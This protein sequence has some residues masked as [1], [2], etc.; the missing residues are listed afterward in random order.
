MTPVFNLHVKKSSNIFL[1]I[2]TS[3]F[4]KASNR[5]PDLT[6]FVHG[7]FGS[8]LKMLKWKMLS[9]IFLII[10]ILDYDDMLSK[11]CNRIF[12]VNLMFYRKKGF[13]V[14][15]YAKVKLILGLVIAKNLLRKWSQKA[16]IFLINRKIIILK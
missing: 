7:G 16:G 8:T 12:F 11:L 4:M 3:S 15:N 14:F 9:T 13:C 10:W 5:D 1:L 2:K 6:L